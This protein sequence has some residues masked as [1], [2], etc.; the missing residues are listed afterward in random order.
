V[1]V[2]LSREMAARLK[3]LKIPVKYTEYPGVNHNSW[4]NAFADPNYL[5]WMFMQKRK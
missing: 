1:D 4:D 2:K 5:E 3:A